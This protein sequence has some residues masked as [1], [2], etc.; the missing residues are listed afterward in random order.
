MSDQDLLKELHIDREEREHK[1]WRS[2]W[3]LIIIAGALVVFAGWG[4]FALM[5][6]ALAVDTAVAESPSG[7]GGREAVLEATGYV[8][9][10]REAAVSFKIPGKLEQVLIEEGERV[11][12][13]QVIAR[14]DDSDASAQ[15]LLA[16]ARL[17][18]A[19]AQLG[20][21]Q[22]KL[23]QAQRDLKRQQEL[24]SKRLASEE[25]LENA[26][27]Q[28]DALSA[29]LEAQRSQVEVAEAEVQVAQVG[30]DNTILRAP[31][32]GVV[33]AKTAQPGEI[34]S[35]SS[36][37]GGYT[38]TG[39]GTIVDM[40]SLE[41]EVDVNEAYIN[42]VK[43][44]QPVQAV[45]DAYPDWKIPAAVIAIIPTADRSKATVKVRIAIK[46]KDPR[47]LPDMGVRVSFLESEFRKQKDALKGVLVPGTAIVER[48]GEPA[49]FVVDGGRAQRRAVTLGQ[50]MGDRR[51]VEDGLRPG[52]RV[53]RDP[54]SGLADG[55]RIA[56]RAPGT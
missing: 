38:R 19:Q 28:L 43:P 29:Q 15:L 54:P 32:S 17:G 53:V 9:A 56:A 34:V 5:G 48:D 10:R 42:R 26:G 3:R 1:G 6:K 23:D 4:Y 46:E 36:A 44:D 45:L 41:I 52:E 8:T 24:R 18:A 37:G 14:L 51:L 50:N 20:Q 27:T 2:Q 39:I 30:Y 49:V 7:A 12:A 40:A 25:A 21:I 22:V 33:V 13:G 47:I 35:P 31:F 55:M 16:K 11:K